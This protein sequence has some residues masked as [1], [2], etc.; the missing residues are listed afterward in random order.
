MKLKIILA[1]AL[2]AVL[3]V[4]AAPAAAF[5]EVCVHMK[6]GAT[7]HE[8]EFWIEYENEEGDIVEQGGSGNLTAGEGGCLPLRVLPGNLFHVRTRANW[9]RTISCAPYPMMQFESGESLIYEI[10]GGVWDNWCSIPGL[11]SDWRQTWP[12]DGDERY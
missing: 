4:V 7:W 6:V 9:G 11:N 3:S 5:A 12:Y 2:S 1:A 10:G 8:A